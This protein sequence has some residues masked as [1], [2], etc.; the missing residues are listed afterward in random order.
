MR[1]ELF[2]LIYILVI[3]HGF[4]KVVYSSKYQL[5]LSSSLLKIITEDGSESRTN[6][7]T[8]YVIEVLDSSLYFSF[9][10]EAVCK[11][12]KYHD[13]VL[14]EPEDS[15]TKPRAICM[16]MDINEIVMQFDGYLNIYKY[17]N[18]QWE[19]E[20]KN[21]NEIFENLPQDS[22]EIVTKEGNPNDYL[23]LGTVS[24]DYNFRG[25]E[26]KIQSIRFGGK[27]FWKPENKS[28]IK[29][30]TRVNYDIVKKTALIQFENFYL[31]YSC[32][33]DKCN[34]LSENNIYQ[35]T[36]G[37]TVVIND[38]NGSTQEGDLSKYL[39][40][41]YDL[42][43]EY[44][45]ESQYNCTE[46][47]FGSQTL[48]NYFGDSSN[49]YPRTLCFH[50]DLKLIFAEFENSIYSYKCTSEGCVPILKYSLDG[51]S[52]SKLTFVTENDMEEPGYNDPVQFDEKSFGFGT[53]FIFKP[54]V[55]CT[56]I[57]YDN[58]PVWSFQSNDSE[59]KYPKKVFFNSFTKMIIV[60]FSKFY[61]IYQY[62]G[63]GLYLIST[64]TLYG[65]LISDFK[66]IG[67]NN[68]ELAKT[69]YET[70]NYPLGYAFACRFNKVKCV[71]FSFKN[72][73]VWKHN[74]QKMGSNYPTNIYVNWDMKMLIVESQAFFN[75]Y[76]YI[77]KEWK[78]IFTFPDESQVP[79]GT[80]EETKPSKLRGDYQSKSIRFNKTTAIIL[81]VL[82]I[83]GITLVALAIKCIM[84]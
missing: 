25:S 32:R 22:V 12:V 81:I 75:A 53:E 72:K 7:R 52:N 57:K 60:D 73:T 69:D 8:K 31:L 54:N 63:S 80:P 78:N 45:F 6:D 44:V 70:V 68:S 48:W 65:S 71:E 47:K 21:L 15:E 35:P 17:I 23:S 30:P 50:E 14:W 16:H 33:S 84:K 67:E 43:S 79:S 24:V 28:D 11:E 42:V 66:F 3:L 77:N 36:D 83:V 20:T 29:Y 10:T 51:F 19:R 18:D 13:Y 34:L 1:I 46:F 40:R 9:R 39:L 62:D 74:P 37:I 4:R 76:M 38:Q 27:V 5:G 58:R 41:K 49:G 61:M 2:K 64:D 55:K 82:A 26:I 56:E 59:N